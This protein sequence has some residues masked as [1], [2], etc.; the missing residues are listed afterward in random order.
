MFSTNEMPSLYSVFTAMA[1]IT[2]SI[3]FFQSMINQIVPRQVRNYL[4]SLLQDLFKAHAPTITFIF[5]K[6]S[7]YG[8]RNQIYAAA[9]VYITTLKRSPHT[10]K[11]PSQ[12]PRQNRPRVQRRNRL[13]RPD[14]RRG[15]RLSG[16]RIGRGLRFRGRSRRS[17]F[18]RGRSSW[19]GRSN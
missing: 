12:I 19:L 17:R 7:E 1:S 2:A 15:R 8:T 14:R 10:D 11:P 6:G 16:R 9:R 3:V 5:E 18:G 4:I 13:G